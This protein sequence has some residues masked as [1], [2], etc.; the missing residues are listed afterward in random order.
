MSGGGT[1]LSSPPF[2]FRGSIGSGSSLTG[3]RCRYVNH[4]VEVGSEAPVPVAL[5]LHELD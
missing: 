3:R 5:A 2:A 4:S 1:F